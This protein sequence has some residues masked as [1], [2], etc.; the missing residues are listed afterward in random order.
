MTRFWI[1]LG[2]LA[3]LVFLWLLF[4]GSVLIKQYRLKKIN[5]AVNEER[6]KRNTVWQELQGIQDIVTIYMTMVAKYGPESPEA[7]AFRFGT[8]CSSMEKLYDQT[9]LMAFAEQADLIDKMYL[10][11]CGKQKKSA[12]A[13]AKPTDS[14]D[15]RAVADT[16]TPGR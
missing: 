2:F 7:K 14:S 1:L 5:K 9:A 13:T 16:G 6:A 10:Q 8:D 4:L 11:V 3:L 15:L 12:S